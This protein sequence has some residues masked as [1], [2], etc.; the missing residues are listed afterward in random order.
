MP[1]ISISQLFD[2]ARARNKAEA[3]AQDAD[4]VWQERRRAE[5]AKLENE[6]AQGL[7]DEHGDL[8][9]TEDEDEDDLDDEDPDEF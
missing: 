1:R 4:P 6:I 3:E 9:E 2:E 7:R 5:A 8:I